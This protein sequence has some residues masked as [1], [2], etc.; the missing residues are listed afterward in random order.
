[1]TELVLVRRPGTA[2]R[3]RIAVRSAARPA[4]PPPAC[5]HFPSTDRFH[6][7]EQCEG[8]D[9]G[10]GTHGTERATEIRGPRGRE[11]AVCKRMIEIVRAAG[12]IERVEGRVLQ[13]RE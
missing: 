2:Q 13:G 8:F 3:M 9:R 5:V 11:P 4:E 7:G 1:A 12:R 10:Q 6:L